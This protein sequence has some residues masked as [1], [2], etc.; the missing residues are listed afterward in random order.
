MLFK[1]FN[2]NSF[3][4]TRIQIKCIQLH[5]NI[6]LCRHDEKK[7]AAI[8][9]IPYQLQKLFVL[10]QLNENTVY[11]KGLLRSFQWDDVNSFQQH[12]VQ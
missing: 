2:T 1:F 5:V 7:I 9:S 3:Y 6:K 4:D 8:D 11:T 12:D 10:L